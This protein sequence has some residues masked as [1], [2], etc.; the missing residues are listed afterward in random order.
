MKKV[1]VVVGIL[2]IYLIIGQV[3]VKT[4]LIPK[5][6]IRIRV[7]ANSDD[8]KDQEIKLE[9]KEDLENYYFDLLKDIK[10]VEIASTMIKNSLSEVEEKVSSIKGDNDFTI[11][12]GMNYFPEKEY[13]GITYEE[14]YYESLVVTLGEGIGKNW[15]CVLFPPLCLLE[16]NDMEEVEYRSFIV[17]LIDKYF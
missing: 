1:L 9:I 11:Q 6:A 14:G 8:S 5:E 7:I 12:Y 16:N 4:N 15:W 17:D 3:S 2:M 10:G 13:K